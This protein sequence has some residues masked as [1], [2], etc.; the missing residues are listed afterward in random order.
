MPQGMRLASAAS[1]QAPIMEILQPRPLKELTPIAP[2]PVRKGDDPEP[3]PTPDNALSANPDVAEGSLENIPLTA[4]N[5]LLRAII[6][7]S[8]KPDI[9]VKFRQPRRPI[10]PQAGKVEA[11]QGCFC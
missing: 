7:T 4:S 11:W 6:E 9:G 8:R 5:V 2:R 10:Q 3:L 1:P